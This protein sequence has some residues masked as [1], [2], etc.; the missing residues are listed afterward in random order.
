M[1]ARGKRERSGRVAPGYPP[2]TVTRPERPKYR[3]RITPFSGLDAL[4]LMIPGATRS[5]RSRLPLAFIF[6]AFGA[7]SFARACLAFIFRA[8]GAASFA[9]AC[10][11]FIFRGFG[12]VSFARACP[13]LSYFAPLAL[14]HSLALV[15]TRISRLWRCVIAR[16]GK[17]R[18]DRTAPVGMG[19]RLVVER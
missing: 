6:R 3:H 8:F 19:C 12:A 2:K 11:A 16:L 10:L 9:R 7:A 4:L 1:K 15:L 14:R 18:P 13:W 5:L 17:P